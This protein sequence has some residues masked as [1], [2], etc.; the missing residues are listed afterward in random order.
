MS[1]APYRWRDRDFNANERDRQ[2]VKDAIASLD[3]TKADFARVI[4][5][6]PATMVNQ[7]RRSELRPGRR[8]VR[9]AERVLAGELVLAAVMAETEVQ[10]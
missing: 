8:T 2:T 10:T 6:K 4:G 9:I 1:K 3:M 7:L 5:I